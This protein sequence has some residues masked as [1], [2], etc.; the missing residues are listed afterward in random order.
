MK[1][2]DSGLL[3][4][5]FVVGR[6]YFFYII[7]FLGWKKTQHFYNKNARVRYPAKLLFVVV[8]L[9]QFISTMH[10]FTDSSYTSKCQE[11]SDK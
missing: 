9:Y 11:I 8:H 1:V 3:S 10:Y 6:L 2:P 7:S 5:F 4:F